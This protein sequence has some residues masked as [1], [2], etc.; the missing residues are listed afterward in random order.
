MQ[1][2]LELPLSSVRVDLADEPSETMLTVLVKPA[3]RSAE[4]DPLL[5]SDPRKRHTVL[6]VQ[7][8]ELETLKSTCAG[9]LRELRQGGWSAIQDLLVFLSLSQKRGFV[10]HS[11][12]ADRQADLGAS[13]A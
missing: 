8:Q 2:W 6:E 1:L 11:G 12:L 7:A 4:G 10:R 13:R 9:L 5:P 3:L